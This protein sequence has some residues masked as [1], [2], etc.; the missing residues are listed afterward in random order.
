VLP[1]LGRLIGSLLL[2]L[3]KGIKAA[4]SRGVTSFEEITDPSFLEFRLAVPLVGGL[5]LGLGSHAVRD[6]D[7]E[8]GNFLRWIL[9]FRLGFL[10][11]EE[12]WS[13]YVACDAMR[14]GSDAV[15]SWLAL[16]GTVRGMVLVGLAKIKLKDLRE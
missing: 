8:R 2:P 7:R 16:C 1:L 12:L 14:D 15:C 6:V 13:C 3:E 10:R 11:G 9:I 5:A 4:T